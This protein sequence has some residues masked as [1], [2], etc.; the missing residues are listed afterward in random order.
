LSQ[1]HPRQIASERAGSA[2]EAFG[3][4]LAVTVVFDAGIVGVAQLPDSLK[5]IGE[6]N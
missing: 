4:G 6:W 1:P 3:V 5:L 2:D